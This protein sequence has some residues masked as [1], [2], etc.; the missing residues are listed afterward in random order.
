MAAESH[1]LLRVIWRFGE[2]LRSAERLI[3]DSIMRSCPCCA[4][5]WSSLCR[6]ESFLLQQEK[7]SA[8]DQHLVIA[9]HSQDKLL[10][11]EKEL[12]AS[13]STVTFTKATIGFGIKAF[14]E[15]LNI[16]APGG[17]LTIVT[18]PVGCVRQRFLNILECAQG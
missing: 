12:N 15:N 17:K 16:R 4:S 13:L 6:I 11:S 8:D 18:G 5:S 2:I 10:E 14:V 7:Q 3:L 1:H 9:V